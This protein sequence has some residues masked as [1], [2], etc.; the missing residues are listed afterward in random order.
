MSAFRD[1]ASCF[2][3][4]LAKGRMMFANV[5]IVSLIVGNAQRVLSLHPI[6]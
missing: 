2:A 4:F 1:L 6:L 3:V 5:T